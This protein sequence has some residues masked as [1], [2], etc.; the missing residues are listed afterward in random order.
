MVEE[1]RQ[2]RDQQAAQIAQLQ[3]RVALQSD[4]PFKSHLNEQL[5]NKARS[6]LTYV[7]DIDQAIIDQDDEEAVNTLSVFRA[8]IGLLYFLSYLKNL[9]FIHI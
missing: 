9:I 2:T 4:R 7:D 3:R 6:Y 8:A 1:F 5:D